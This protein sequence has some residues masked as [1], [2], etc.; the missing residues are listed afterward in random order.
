ML[1]TTT[2]PEMEFS[3]DDLEQA[4]SAIN[5]E[6]KQ[7]AYCP[8][9]NMVTYKLSKMKR[10]ERGVTIEHMICNKLL[11][12]GY[13]A[14]V[15]NVTS[16]CDIIVYD[17]GRKIR[18]EVK[19][20]CLTNTNRYNFQN[21]KTEVFDICF[22]AFVKPDGLDVRFLDNAE[23]GEYLYSISNQTRGNNGY[24]IGTNGMCENL[25]M[26]RN[27]IRMRGMEYVERGI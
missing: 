7:S 20:S 5:N 2:T 17:N 10:Q 1:A 25:M 23:V 14:E 22:F 8:T 21:I 3:V 15:T 9:K 13:D 18:C 12:M 4:H 26:A 11:A 19:S 24:S 6:T 27:G 16:P